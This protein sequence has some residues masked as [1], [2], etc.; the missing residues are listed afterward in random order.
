MRL[1]V[2]ERLVQVASDTPEVLLILR[3]AGGELPSFNFVRQPRSVQARTK[4]EQEQDLLEA[5]RS[6]GFIDAI[7]IESMVPRPGW[8]LVT[9]LRFSVQGRP[10]GAL[11]FYLPLDS[12]ELVGT[13]TADGTQYAI[14]RS[15]L[16][17]ILASITVHGVGLTRGAGEPRKQEDRDLLE[18]GLLSIVAILAM[19]YLG[20][21]YCRR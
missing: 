15:M 19:A 20:L 17:E 11:A 9:Q 6:V 21:K 7:V 8:P 1:N 16:D 5:Y 12:S 18:L 2:P 3:A 10:R 4:A 13:F 14:A